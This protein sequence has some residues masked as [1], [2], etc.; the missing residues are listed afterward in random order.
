VLHHLAQSNTARVRADWHPNFGG[1]QQNRDVLV[2]TTDAGGIDLKNI[3]GVD[4]Q[5]VLE[6]H[7]VGD[8]HTRGDLD[9]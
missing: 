1:Q 3:G 6:H 5:E 9:R 7:S 8:V 4:L 2:D